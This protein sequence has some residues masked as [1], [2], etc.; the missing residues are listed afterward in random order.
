[1]VKEMIAWRRAVE[2]RQ[3]VARVMRK[4]C[5]EPCLDSAAHCVVFA[6]VLLTIA[7]FFVCTI[8]VAHLQDLSVLNANKPFV[9]AT[10]ACFVLLGGSL[11]FYALVA[12]LSE[13]IRS[14]EQDPDEA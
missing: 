14:L 1:M 7:L 12:R 6:T 3:R 9:V 4:C 8:M 13:C 2:R 5:S 11:G 10:V